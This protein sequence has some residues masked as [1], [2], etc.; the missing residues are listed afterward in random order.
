MRLSIYAIAIASIGSS[1]AISQ[2][3]TINPWAFN[4]VSLGDIG[5]ASQ[6]YGSDFQGSAAVLGS[7]YFSG[8]SLHDVASA[9]VGTPYS[10]Y[11]GG[12]VTITGSINNGG[13]EAG[14]NVTMNG[15]SIF[16]QINA[17]GNLGGS[18]G[19][20]Y[21]NV[22]LGGTK[23]T[24]NPLTV[25]GS[26]TSN[27][28][29]LPSVS[30]PGIG[31]YLRQ[32][33]QALGA[34]PNNNVVVDQYHNGGLSVALNPG[35]N[36]VSLSSSDLHNAWGFTVTGSSN[37]TL[38]VNVT[39]ANV[40]FDST[41]WTYNGGVDAGQVLLNMANAETLALS[42]GNSVNLLAPNAATHFSSGVLTGN[43]IVGSLTGSGQVNAGFFNSNAIPTY[44]PS[45]GQVP[46]PA[47]L[48]MLAFGGLLLARR[49]RRA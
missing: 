23:T 32:T 43:L 16:G 8:F 30:L 37:A 38:V 10:L 9:G 26:I 36:V 34:L 47:T 45:S 13:V 12:N 48:A 7:A 1:A 5:T 29:V 39:D 49:R 28:A 22:T 4:V 15:A 2:A 6:S 21:G 41:N 19:T 18:G 33:S 40:T 11:A 3:D 44:T 42:G 31:D 24:G 14:G 20:V 17:G 25:T 46:E 27:T 35:V